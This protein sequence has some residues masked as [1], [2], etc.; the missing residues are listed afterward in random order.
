MTA[1]M[2]GGVALRSKALLAPM[3]GVS[4]RAYRELCMAMGAGYCVSEMVSS[5]ALSFGS[6]K[7]VELMEIDNSERPC[8]IQIFGD[9]PLCMAQAAESAMANKPDI[10][11]I[12]MGCPAPKISGSGSGSA[13]MRDPAL[14]G[15]LTEAVVRAV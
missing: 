7:S 15:R 2:I 1:G 3:A 4:D 14:C 9:D 6:K 13:L 12:N 8:G 10:I 5:K 11:D